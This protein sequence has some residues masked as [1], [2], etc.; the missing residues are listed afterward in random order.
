MDPAWHTQP[1]TFLLGSRALVII[2]KT[3]NAKY[4]LINSLSPSLTSVKTVTE[5]EVDMVDKHMVW[6]EQTM[7]LCGLLVKK[8][9]LH[10][11]HRR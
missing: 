6:A 7:F 8:P 10:D 2:S 4:K 5:G 1:L 9:A 11:Q 3:W